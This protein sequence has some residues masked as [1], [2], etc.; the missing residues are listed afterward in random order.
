MDTTPE[1]LRPRPQTREAR[2]HFASSRALRAGLLR[3]GSEPWVRSARIDW[4][5]NELVLT[6]AGARPAAA[7][8]RPAAAGPPR[9][10]AIEGG[11]RAAA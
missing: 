7:G 4:V 2:V 8:A 1:R 11:G 10:H 3:A 6:L 9:L 5:R